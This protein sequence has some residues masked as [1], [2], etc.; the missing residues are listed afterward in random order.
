MKKILALFSFLTIS[1]VFYAQC[2]SSGNHTLTTQAAVDAFC[3]SESASSCTITG[4]LKIEGIGITNLTAL[5]CIKEVVGEFKIKNTSII[6]LGGIENIIKFRNKFKIEENPNLRNLDGLGAIGIV[7]GEVKIKG[8]SAMT[9]I[10]GLSVITSVGKLKIENNDL[11][12][13]L[14]GLQNITSFG[15]ELKVTGNAILGST[16][17]TDCLS[18]TAGFCGVPSIPGNIN[19]GGGGGS[20]DDNHPTCTLTDPEVITGCDDALPVEFIDFNVKEN[21]N[22]QAIISWTTSTELNNKHFV[23]ERSLDCRNFDAI[24][25]ITGAGTTDLIQTYSYVDK[26]PALFAYYRLK[27]VDYD[28]AY[29]FSFLVSLKMESFRARKMDVYPTMAENNVTIRFT[30]FDTPKTL[31]MVSDSFGR[32]MHEEEVYSSD[33]LEFRTLDLS[34]YENGLHRVIIFDGDQYKTDHFVVSKMN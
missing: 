2:P 7:P 6:T 20:A 27:Q 11:L 34:K 28:G 24:G 5:S 19:F 13:T 26:S 18:V 31:L 21:H 9:N 10:N 14:S 15:S 16:G 1:I 17:A 30:S 4:F 3:N 32:L 8:N 29:A 12:G 22:H 25:V 23:I 33:E